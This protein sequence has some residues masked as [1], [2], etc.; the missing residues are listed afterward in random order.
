VFNYVTIPTGPGLA[1]EGRVHH[2]G[3]VD[4]APIIDPWELAGAQTGLTRQTLIDAAV[5]AVHTQLDIHAL[6]PGADVRT[7]CH[8]FEE[9]HWVLEGEPAVSLDGRPMRLRAGD[10][11]AVPVGMPVA[12]AN[13]GDDTARL[14]TVSTPIRLGPDTPRRDT[15]L[16]PHRDWD[17]ALAP[18]LPTGPTARL[19][20]HYEGT[21]PQMEA[22]KLK[23]RPRG[24][25]T[26]GRDTALVV[27][28]GISVKMM[29]D[30]TLG[31]SLLTMF[32]VDYEPGGSAQ[33]HD[34]PFEEAYL[35]MEG[36]IEGEFE[37]QPYTFRRGDVAWAGV[38]ATHGF[39]ND[40]QTHVRWLETQAPQ[41]PV[42]HS[43]RWYDDWK[44]LEG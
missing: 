5:G 40:G 7:H 3:R 15:F 36:E 12:W 16:L 34:H 20:G 44:K 2:V 37:G 24:R 33:I 1:E 17:A 22:L 32:T 11:L 25:P 6:A 30:A 23:D 42:R 9:A 39:F 10:Y 35:F 4:D 13:P 26:A 43:Y 31:A 18:A 8:S 38:G 41:P 29:V 21:P 27:Y 19:V 14:L 28:S